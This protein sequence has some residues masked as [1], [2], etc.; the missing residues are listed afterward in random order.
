MRLAP[1][2]PQQQDWC[3]A[4]ANSAFDEMAGDPLAGSW[5]KAS[6]GLDENL[7][8]CLTWSGC[9]SDVLGSCHGHPGNK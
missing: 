9:Q 8:L 4:L 3:V 1:V 7:D 2:S 6:N 5:R